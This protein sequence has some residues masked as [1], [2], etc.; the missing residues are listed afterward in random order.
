MEWAPAWDATEFWTDKTDRLLVLQTCGVDGTQPRRWANDAFASRTQRSGASFTF[1]LVD[2]EGS[3]GAQNAVTA[4]GGQSGRLPQT[5]R[6]EK[7]CPGGPSGFRG[8]EA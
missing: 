7:V 2:A 4:Q 6:A 5:A 1:G 8:T 3:R